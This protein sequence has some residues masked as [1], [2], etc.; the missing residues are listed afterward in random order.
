MSTNLFFASRVL[1]MCAGLVWNRTT[2]FSLDNNFIT[3]LITAFVRETVLQQLPMTDFEPASF[4]LLAS[5]YTIA[6][7]HKCTAHLLM[8]GTQSKDQFFF[9]RDAT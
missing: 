1:L 6:A 5:A 3:G 8:C 2:I 4:H 7:L 9:P